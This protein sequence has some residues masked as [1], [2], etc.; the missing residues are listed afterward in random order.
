[1]PVD[2]EGLMLLSSFHQSREVF[3]FG[4]EMGERGTELN[5]PTLKTDVYYPLL[6]FSKLLQNLPQM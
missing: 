4:H 2:L 5:P 1:M 6:P 3:P